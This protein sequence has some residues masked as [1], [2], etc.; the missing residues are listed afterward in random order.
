[1]FVWSAEDRRQRALH[2]AETETMSRHLQL[3][4]QLARAN[5]HVQRASV[6]ALETQVAASKARNYHTSLFCSVL[7]FIVILQPFVS[8]SLSANKD[9]H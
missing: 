6:V 7:C 9:G 8:V 1:M 2:V 4:S 3:I 5:E